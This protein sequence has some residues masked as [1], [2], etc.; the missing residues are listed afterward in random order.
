MP[1]LPN[2]P[3]TKF[4]SEYNTGVWDFGRLDEILKKIDETACAATCLDK[5]AVL[6]Y[7]AAN[8]QLYQFLRPFITLSWKKF[9]TNTFDATCDTLWL[10]VLEWHNEYRANPQLT[11]FPL[12][13]V[14]QLDI[15]HS[16][17]LTVKQT[18][19]FGLVMNRE[20]S[21]KTKIRQYMRVVGVKG[22]Q[23]DKR[24]KV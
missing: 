3:K 14:K 7:F 9:M 4:K 22:G 16:N 19:G 17:L 23:F 2:S 8:K 1:S 6:P 11:D 5:Q 21:T 10:D 20:T 15:F 13:L 18:F 12:G 24:I